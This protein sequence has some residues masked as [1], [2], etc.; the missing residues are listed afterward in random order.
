MLLG[1]IT[2]T[3]FSQT[4]KEIIGVNRQYNTPDTT[5][6]FCFLNKLNFDN[7]I[8]SLI[9]YW[10][11]PVKNSVGNISWTQMDIPGIGTDLNI[12]LK[13]GICTMAKGDLMCEY[14]KNKKDKEIRL[15]ELKS[16][17]SRS[18]E[19]IISDKNGKNIIDSKAKTEIV[20]KVLEKIV[21]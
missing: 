14:F 17:Q 9:K 8:D 16:N 7:S 10:G 13:D 6:T 18:V 21:D 3:T 4:K 20:M 5:N 12:V 1:F 15:K 19:I 2:L 11:T